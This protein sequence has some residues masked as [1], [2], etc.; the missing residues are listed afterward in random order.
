M[1]RFFSESSAASCTCF[2][3]FFLDLLL[4]HPVVVVQ[5]PDVAFQHVALVFGQHGFLQ[6]DGL[7][8]PVVIVLVVLVMVQAKHFRKLA[9][10]V[11]LPAAAPEWL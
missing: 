2:L 5:H 3:G 10:R 9:H 1:C 6:T 4:P 7:L 8:G 11:L